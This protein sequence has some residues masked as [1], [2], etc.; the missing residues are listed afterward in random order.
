MERVSISW[1]TGVSARRPAALEIKTTFGVLANP[2]GLEGY[3][4]YLVRR[5]HGQHVIC[6]MVRHG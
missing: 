2:Y 1:T 3:I 4:P 5:N 6:G